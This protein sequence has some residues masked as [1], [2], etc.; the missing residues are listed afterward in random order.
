ME[1][2][3]MDKPDAPRA[4]NDEHL[5]RIIIDCERFQRYPQQLAIALASY[6]TQPYEMGLL[7]VTLLPVQ[8]QEGTRDGGLFGI[9]TAYS[10]AMHG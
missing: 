10:V 1:S 9:A 4:S 6:I 8:Q 3:T 2:V 5:Y 7:M